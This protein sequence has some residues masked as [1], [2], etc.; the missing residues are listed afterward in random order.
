MAGILDKKKR[1]IDLVVTQEGKRQI[2]AGKL[3]V[4][5]ASATDMHAYY[6]R[7]E[8]YEDVTKNIYFEVMERPENAI[9]LETDDSGRLLQFDISPTESI[10]GDQIFKKENV[11]ATSINQLKIATGSQF[12]SLTNNLT[13]NFIDNFKKNYFISSKDPTNPKN[14]FIISSNKVKFNI[15]NTIP[16]AT[17][18]KE[19]IVNVNDAE[20]F[21]LDKKLSH[22]PNFAF[23][24]PVN[25]D[26]TSYGE[27][28]DYRSTTSTTWTNII[29]ELGNK[30]FADQ[31]AHGSLI[32][33]DFEARSKVLQG[34]IG[35]SD[36]QENGDITIKKDYKIFDFNKTSENNNLLIQIYET[37]KNKIKKLD[38]VDGGTFIVQDDKNNNIE[39]KVFYAGK[40]YFDD[41][42]TPTFINLFTLILE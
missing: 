1:F 28:E 25:E 15:K 42:N 4:E 39:K 23:L 22:L 12:A 33:S 16:F 24:P 40:I 8:K 32:G 34:L 26:G 3:K 14:E 21:I 6:D 5:Y 11:T 10:T 37:N 7:S 13:N 2:A 31:L 27:Y 36:Y 29:E 19:Q 30:A 41:Y 35:D 38:I 18:P 17:G 9:V 20:P